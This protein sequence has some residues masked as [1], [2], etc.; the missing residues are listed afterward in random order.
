MGNCKSIPSKNLIML[1]DNRKVPKHATFID[2]PIF[3]PPISKYG[4]IIDCV[5]LNHF[6][7]A[8]YMLIPNTP[9]FSFNIYL[10]DLHIPD[11]NSIN[12]TERFVANQGIDQMCKIFLN[13]RVILSNIFINYNG[14]YIA[15]IKLDKKNQILTISDWLCMHNY[16]F[17]KTKKNKNE[18]WYS[19]YSKRPV[20]INPNKKIIIDNFQF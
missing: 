10:H 6:V 15:D 5:T 4:K 17:K 11:I 14:N 20:L 18:S 3:I 2:A 16:G 19:L 13:K 1:K 7:V 9:L 8:A 12:E